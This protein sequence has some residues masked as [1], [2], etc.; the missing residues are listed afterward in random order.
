MSVKVDVHW[1]EMSIL[2]AS[3]RYTASFLCTSQIPQLIIEKISVEKSQLIKNI[4]LHIILLIL[5]AKKIKI[6]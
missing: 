1:H 3:E 6:I 2:W 5:F 4:F